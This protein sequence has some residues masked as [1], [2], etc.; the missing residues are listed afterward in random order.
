ME[1]ITITWLWLCLPCGIPGAG[2]P[3]EVHLDDVRLFPGWEVTER[4]RRE[5]WDRYRYAERRHNYA[6]SENHADA[7]HWCEVTRQAYR[8]WD[9]WDDLL[10]VHH[11]WEFCGVPLY[12]LHRMREMLTPRLFYHGQMPGPVDVRE[13]MTEM[14]ALP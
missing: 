8:S 3:S 7:G 2:Q 11:P 10:R 6:V 5:A 13:P 1:A 14:V 9:I 4:E 12:R